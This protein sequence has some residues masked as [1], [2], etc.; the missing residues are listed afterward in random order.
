MIKR[1]WARVLVVLLVLTIGVPRFPAAAILHAAATTYLAIGYDSSSIARNAA[2]ATGSIAGDTGGSWGAY[3]GSLATN[4]YFMV[5]QAPGRSDYSLQLVTNS[6]TISTARYGQSITEKVVLSAAVRMNDTKH[7]RRLTIASKDGENISTSSNVLLFNETGELRSVTGKLIAAYSADTWYTLRIF[8]DSANR[9]VDYWVNGAYKVSDSL[10]AAWLN[11]NAVTWDQNGAASKGEGQLYVDD[12]KIAGYVPSSG[13]SLLPQSLTLHETKGAALTASFSP[14]DASDTRVNWSSS[15]EAVALVDASGFVTAISEG[16]AMVTLTTYEGG[17][18]AQIPVTVVPFVPVESIELPDK[19]TVAAGMTAELHPVFEPV[20]ATDQQVSWQS[21]DSS[22]ASIDSA[23]VVTAAAVGQ[24]ELTAVSQAN[25]SIV[26]HTTVEVTPFIAVTGISLPS[27]SSL[28]RG[29]TAALSP[30]ILPANASNQALTWT[31]S[32]P[33]VAAVSDTGIVSGIGTGIAV[34]CAVTVNGGFQACTEVTVLAPAVQGVALPQTIMVEEADSVR[35]HAAFTPE[36]P[37]NEDVTWTISDPSVAGVDANGVITGFA[38]GTAILTVTTADGGFQASSAVQVVAPPDASANDEYDSIRIRWKQTLSGSEQLN[39][40]DAD[41]QLAIEETAIAAQGYWDSMSLSSGAAQLWSDLPASTTSSSFITNHYDRLKTMA[42]AYSTRGSLLYHDLQLKSDI[43]QALEWMNDHV[44]TAA[45][46]EYGNWWD[47]EIGS[48]NRLADVLVLM[49]NDLTSTELGQYIAV[50]DHYIGDI[51]SSAFSKTGANLVDIMLIE[52]RIGLLEKNSARLYNVR[53]GMDPLYE[54]VT[55]GDGFYEDGSFIQ[56]TNVAYTAS[57]GEVLIRGIG[58][59]LFLLNASTWEPVNPDAQH[60]YEWIEYAFVPILYRGHA[61]DMVRGRAIA[62]EAQNND[63]SGSYILIG[64]ARVA[65]N[66]PADKKLELQSIVKAHLVYLLDRGYSYYDFPLDL[67][68]TLRGLVEDSTVV[69]APETAA[70]YELNAMARSI[71]KGDGYLFG[72]SK[73]SS[74]V[75]TYELT[76]GENTKGWYTGDGMTYLYNSDDAQYSGDYWATLNWYRLPGTTVDTRARLSSD[77]QNGDGEAA[78]ANTWAGGVTLGSYGVSGMNL[79]QIGT[80]LIANKSWFMFDNE[81][82]ALGAGIT[83]TDSRVIESIVE[84]RKLKGDNSNELT[85]DG[86]LVAATVQAATIA[87]PSWVHLEGNAA[88][89]NIGY[90]FPDHQ[91]LK[92]ERKAQTGS[93][94][95]INANA[96]LS[97]DT[98]S[99]NFL[100]MWFDHG[101]NPTNA[102]YQYI[103][104]PNATVSQTAAYSA[105]PDVSIVANTADVQAVRENSLAVTGFNFWKDSL[106]TADFVTSNKKASVMVQDN[107]E[108][109]TLVLSVADPTLANSGTIE[110]ELNRMATAVISSDARIEVVQL[111]PT[112]KLKAHVDGSMGRSLEASFTLVGS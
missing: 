108:A 38:A 86:A 5:K 18:T 75:K 80:T 57:Y 64:L 14:L 71:H 49:Y 87:N 72:I 102:A 103:V 20:D 34:I 41:A 74:R 68:E 92:L 9:S 7:T 36:Q 85:V 45:G 66:A 62:R 99:A 77:Y 19:L 21:A 69:P 43:L 96:G 28:I 3:N 33:L 105:A 29:E 2:F 79:N 4:D 46:S 42:I 73:S 93:W 25:S 26:A 54:Y 100:T 106:T 35:V 61:L 37:R 27:A 30:I 31:S 17:Y 52:A 8:L 111:S 63:Y 48:P 15:N 50:M 16:N 110:L 47:W 88:G 98:R 84:Q 76:N 59:L 107:A 12:F 24:T 6:K 70:H 40:A 10:P 65:Q 67:A 78:P 51:T 13:V 89:A 101:A 1:R 32:N 95:S 53:D 94:Y 56:H 83:S 112:I 44:Y 58:N 90:V 104:L 97:T 11:I 60:V 39:I 81:I 55:S 23:G 109:N 82:V 91:A 22:I